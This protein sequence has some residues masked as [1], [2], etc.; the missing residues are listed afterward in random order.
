M[1]LR[2]S[3]YQW[4]QQPRPEGQTVVEIRCGNLSRQ[5]GYH[6]IADDD[7]IVHVT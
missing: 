3:T 2:Y 7:L 4:D 1:I 5:R 6:G